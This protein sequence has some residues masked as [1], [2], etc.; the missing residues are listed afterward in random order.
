MRL[1]RFVVVFILALTCAASSG[2]GMS[3]SQVSTVIAATKSAY[4]YANKKC[5]DLVQED[6]T[7]YTMNYL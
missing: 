5:K 3:I 7:S 2:Y 6:C 1:T 4:D